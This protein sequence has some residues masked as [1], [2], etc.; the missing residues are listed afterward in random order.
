MIHQ[1]FGVCTSLVN[2]PDITL[3]LGVRVKE[4][5]HINLDLIT[6]GTIIRKIRFAS[7]HSSPVFKV[8][9]RFVEMTLY[10]LMHP[11]FRY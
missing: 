4:D 3:S 11:M 5:H 2:E 7:T 6:L 9:V 10:D 1:R 8:H